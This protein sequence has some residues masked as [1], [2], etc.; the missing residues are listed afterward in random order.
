M[1]R[2]LIVLAAIMA[3]LVLV[4]SPA[5]AQAQAPPA[6]TPEAVASQLCDMNRTQAEKNAGAIIAQNLK[7]I[8]ELQA[9]V[10]SLKAAAKPAE[11]K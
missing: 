6:P 7:T 5:F 10:A 4:A 3:A 11:K 8:A 1:L 9:E 2:D